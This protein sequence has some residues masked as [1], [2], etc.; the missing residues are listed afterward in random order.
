MDAVRI[1]LLGPVEIGP[2]GAAIGVRSAKGR[3]L[4]AA[5]A[6]QCG[7]PVSADH[8]ID[9][10]WDQAPPRSARTTLRGHV[11]R[12]RELLVAVTRWRAPIIRTEPTGYRLDLPRTSVDLH[13]FRE[14]RAQAR[15]TPDPGAECLLLSQALELWRG[16][17][18][19]GVESDTL[20]RDPGLAVEEERGQALTR[21]L[22]L[23][24][25]AG[26]HDQV[27]ATAHA[28]L[29]G[30][31][32]SETVWVRLISALAAADRTAEALSQY[33]RVHRLLADELGTVP[34]SALLSLHRVLSGRGAAADRGGQHPRGS[35]GARSA[36]SQALSRPG[37]SGP[38][39]AD[40]V[41]EGG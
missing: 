40:H 34:C 33:H 7:Q 8:L 23:D 15:A 30:N 41:R 25:D 10:L 39:V 4:L 12:L 24:H 2:P 26:R 28:Y 27:I 38:P 18:L 11:R 13:V 35:V 31:P 36:G 9:A 17:A 1:G 3:T 5:L 21:R 22:E 19:D 32:L 20:L 37:L 14:L 6:I 29:A 16:R